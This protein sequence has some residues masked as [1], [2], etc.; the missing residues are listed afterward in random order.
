VAVLAD[1]RCA[2]SKQARMSTLTLC[3]QLKGY[4]VRFVTDI[5]VATRTKIWNINFIEL[6]R[7]LYPRFATSASFCNLRMWRWDCGTARS[8]TDWKMPFASSRYLIRISHRP[9]RNL[10]HS[11]PCLPFHPAPDQVGKSYRL[12]RLATYGCRLRACTSRLWCS[13]D[14]P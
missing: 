2:K 5:E 12:W 3:F 6:W 4:E 14:K 7:E 11:M 1:S 9:T 10:D 13:N 8:S